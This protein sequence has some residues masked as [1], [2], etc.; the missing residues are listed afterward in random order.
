MKKLIIILCLISGYGLAA[1][2]LEIPTLKS[3]GINAKATKLETKQFDF[4]EGKGLTLNQS[5]IETF[6]SEGRLKA[7]SRTVHSSGQ[8]YLYTY[9]LSRKGILE[10]EKIVNAANNETV[11]ITT[12]DYKKGNL[13]KTTQVQGT[14]TFVKNYSYNKSGHLIKMEAI[15]NGTSKGEEIFNVDDKG[16]RIQFSQKQPGQ[17]T[18][19]PIS[20]YTYAIEG[21]FEIKTEIRNVNGAKYEIV[22]TK[23]L[24]ANRNIK[25]TTKNLSNSESGF[26]NSLYVEDENGTW[27]KGEMVD[28]QFG[29][30]RL[31]LRKITYIDGTETGRLSMVAEDARA[32]Y[33]RQNNQYQVLYNGKVTQTG[34]AEDL[35]DTNDRLV[36]NE[37]DSAMILLKGYDDKAYQSTWH[38]AQIISFGKNKMIWLGRKNGIDVFQKGKKLH[39]GSGSNTKINTYKVGNTTLVYVSDKVKKT[40]IAKDF[41]SEDHLGKIQFPEF[42]D[43]HTYWGKATDSTYILL[44]HGNSLGINSQSED[45]K[46]NMIVKSRAGDWYSL[47]GFR[48][49]FDNKKPG[50]LFS[51]VFLNDPLKDIKEGELYE[52]DFSSF[53]HD[54]FKKNQ[55]NL[56]TR[57]GLKVT[58]L[59]IQSV[60]T[61]D[62]ELITYFP[63]TQQYLKMDGYYAVSGEEDLLDQP[64]TVLL[65]GSKDGYYMYN[66]GANINFY[67]QGVA[68]SKYRFGARNLDENTKQYGAILYDSVRNA[69]YGM[70]YDLTLGD[71]MGPMKKLPL[72]QYNIYLL[73]LAGGKWVLF[74]RGGL[75]GSYEFTAM[76]NGTAVYFFKDNNGKIGA[77]RFEG[78]TDAKAGDFMASDYVSGQEATK[79]SARLG[80]N[81]LIP[82]EKDKKP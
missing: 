32:R 15:E 53:K 48:E 45:K 43:E 74:N 40:F 81:P 10:E 47:V 55:Y 68:A 49:L 18:A 28:K 11:R 31:V 57:D 62:D 82:V 56:K 69:S 50:E 25:E 35:A 77:Y 42:T 23:D 65:G 79:L 19:K 22:T 26:I 36:Y 51:A 63:L 2:V 37:A 80:V 21:E 30:S 9:K 6:D 59:A 29:R 41:D 3:K 12:Y 78:Y 52:A 20:T 38:E 44:S 34:T 14:I 72:I 16:R 8:K 39:S 7:I 33:Y 70:N 61:K 60:K 58:G 75:I 71:R 13:I 5:D 46:G 24:N 4:V 1:Q 67:Q 27:I 54:N 64:V 17:E 66:D 76:D 73:K